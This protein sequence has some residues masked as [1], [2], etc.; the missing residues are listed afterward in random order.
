MKEAPWAYSVN[1][2]Y[3]V[4]INK[5]QSGLDSRTL[6]S[7]L[8]QAKIQ[9]RPLWQPLHLSNAHSTQLL[10]QYEVAE[11]LNRDGL[12]LPCS[13]NLTTKDQNYVI[14]TVRNILQEQ[15]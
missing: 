4:M 12:S 6:L 8:A 15:K 1:W 13:V 11:Q 2:L 10:F 3:T 5:T 14:A 9:T 7:K